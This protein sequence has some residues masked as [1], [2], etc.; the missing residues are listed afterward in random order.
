[1]SSLYFVEGCDVYTM[2]TRVDEEGTAHKYKNW[3][4]DFSSP[5]RAKEWCDTI[6]G[7]INEQGKVQAYRPGV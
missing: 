4:K 5:A 2:V 3:V 6:N 1:M 7:G